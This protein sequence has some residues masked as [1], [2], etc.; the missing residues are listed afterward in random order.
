MEYFNGAVNDEMKD[1]LRRIKSLAKRIRSVFPLAMM[2]YDVCFS[3]AVS[4]R[5]LASVLFEA[6]L[7]R[8]VFT[9]LTK[10][11][12]LKLWNWPAE[13]YQTLVDKFCVIEV[14]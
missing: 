3:L 14:I 5:T 6:I 8:S 4:K 11:Q 2:S 7:G 10:K 9:S 1:A 13:I 12:D